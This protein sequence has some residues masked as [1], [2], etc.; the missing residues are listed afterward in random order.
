MDYSFLRLKDN[1]KDAF[2]V[3]ENPTYEIE[4]VGQVHLVPNETYLQITNSDI[5]ISFT[6]LKV[7]IV[8]YCNNVLENVTD[9]VFWQSFTDSNGI[10]QIVWEYINTVDYYS[11]ELLSVLYLYG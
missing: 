3:S 10:R 11:C 7:E 4:Y 9:R 2:K 5:D 8:D 6:N 1:F